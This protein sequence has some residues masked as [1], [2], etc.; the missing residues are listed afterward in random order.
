MTF[1]DRFVR[2]SIEEATEVIRDA[3][4][5]DIVVARQQWQSPTV[6]HIASSLCNACAI[7]QSAAPA[8]TSSAL[9]QSLG[10]QSVATQHVI[11]R[12]GVNTPDTPM[13]KTTDLIRRSGE[14]MLDPASFE[15]LWLASRLFGV[16]HWVLSQIDEVPDVGVWLPLLPD[17]GVM[18]VQE[19]KEIFFDDRSG[20]FTTLTP[21]AASSVMCGAAIPSRVLLNLIRR[22]YLMNLEHS[23]ADLELIRI[24]RLTIVEEIKHFSLYLAPS[25]QAL[26]PDF[27]PG[28][29]YVVP[30]PQ[31]AYPSSQAAPTLTPTET[32]LWHAAVD[33]AMFEA[34]LQSELAPALELPELPPN[35]RAWPQAR[36][37]AEPLTD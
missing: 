6:F 21:Q 29:L 13:A 37:L 14:F 8:M 3:R 31:S 10:H 4:V 15:N 18:D 23:M 11:Q 32:R 12:R 16:A 5:N 1:I 33:K 26:H 35:L 28:R 2:M 7:F 19:A 34:V 36:L 27:V 20:F 24:R 30:W 25:E 9:A 22:F 17:F